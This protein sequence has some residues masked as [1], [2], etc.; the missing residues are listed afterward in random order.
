MT[1]A[2]WP[3]PV[4]NS[5]QWLQQRIH[6]VNTQP[7]QMAWGLMGFSHDQSHSL[8]FQDEIDRIIVELTRWP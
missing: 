7:R 1:T 4:G 8:A 6:P 3:A 5:A 2:G